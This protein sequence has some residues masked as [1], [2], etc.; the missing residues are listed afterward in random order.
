MHPKV[1]ELPLRQI[2]L[3]GEIVNQAVLNALAARFPG[4]RITHIYASTEVGVG[5]SVR[6]GREGY[7]ASLIKRPPK[8]IALMVKDDRLWLRPEDPVARDIGEQRLLR[9]AEG[10]VDTGDRVAKRGE[11]YVFLGRDTG[12][13]NIGGEKVYPEQV[14][15]VINV[16]DGAGLVSVRAKSNSLVGAVVTAQIVPSRPVP[17]EAAFLDRVLAHC[18]AHLVREAVPADI[19]TRR[20]SRHQSR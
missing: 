15:Q 19:R 18:R 3:G 8:G 2:T 17:D 11:R 6:D 1:N 5:F 16:L 7:P 20:P 14:E 13:I 12:V 4:V 10:F 9:D